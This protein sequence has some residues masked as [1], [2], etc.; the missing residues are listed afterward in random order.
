MLECS[1]K[2]E[3]SVVTRTL[4]LIYPPSLVSQPVLC[5][6][7]RLFHLTVNI[8][9]AQISLEDGWLEAELTGDEGEIAQAISWLDKQGV[10]IETLS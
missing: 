1:H 10:T 8:R 6:L 7:I 5:Q 2:V 4:R 9:R 3:G